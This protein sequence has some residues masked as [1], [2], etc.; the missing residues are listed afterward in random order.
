MKTYLASTE[1]PDE[2]SGI[3]IFRRLAAADRYGVHSISPV[4]EDADIILFTECHLVSD[5]RLRTILQSPL[6]RRF[7]EKCD[8]Y[9][10]QDRPWCALPGV[11]VSM[12][13]RD[14]R[15]EFQ[16]SWGYCGIEEPF[17]RLGLAGPP[18]GNPDLLVSFDGTRSH[19]SRASL[20]K[21]AHERAVIEESIGFVFFD[22][23]SVGLT[24]R[25]TRFAQ[26]LYRSKI[27]ALPAW[28]RHGIDTALRDDGGW[29]RAC[30]HL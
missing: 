30:D 14:F 3:P 27:R 1:I 8:V 20:Y 11:F 7:H 23:T 10:E 25:R 28:P 29:A 12:P 21:L 6:V 9:D 4:P 24:E 15:E 22:P 26:L 5:W 17:A 18:G 16:R 2:Q 13:K 19:R